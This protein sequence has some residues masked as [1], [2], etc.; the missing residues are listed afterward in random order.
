MSK[1]QKAIDTVGYWEA[2]EWGASVTS[3]EII[4]RDDESYWNPIVRYYAIEHGEEFYFDMP[5]LE[6]ID[7]YEDLQKYG[8]R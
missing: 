3:Y 5:Y 1:T 8:C 6:V 2:S 4:Q 7:R